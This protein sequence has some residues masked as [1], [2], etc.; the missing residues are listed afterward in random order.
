LLFLYRLTC[1]LLTTYLLLHTPNLIGPY[2]LILLIPCT[3]F[4]TISPL[5]SLFLSLIRCL[6]AYTFSFH[7]VYLCFSTFSFP[8]FYSSCPTLSRVSLP[9]FH[10]C[11]QYESLD[12]KS[13]V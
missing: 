10:S 1:S 7:I 2:H 4:P 12:R 13:V 3:L 8:P 5:L 11:N 9:L 6:I